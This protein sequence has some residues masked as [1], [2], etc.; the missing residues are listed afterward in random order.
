MPVKIF[1]DSVGGQ[2][3]ETGSGKK[4]QCIEIADLGY[5]NRSPDFW[6]DL[7]II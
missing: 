1:Q 7:F 3:L 4:L 5:S 2:N 6:V